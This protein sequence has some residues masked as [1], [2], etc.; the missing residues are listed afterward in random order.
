[1]ELIVKC[2]NCQQTSKIRIDNSCVRHENTEVREM[3]NEELYVVDAIRT[4]KKC[5]TKWRSIEIHKYAG[6][7]AIIGYK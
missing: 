4:C 3:G 6:E 7:E 5:N 1:M 2:E